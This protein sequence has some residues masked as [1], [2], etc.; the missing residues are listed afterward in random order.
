MVSSIRERDYPF[1]TDPESEIG[2]G[3]HCL[4]GNDL[5]GYR[6]VY[7]IRANLSAPA[8]TIPCFLSP[9]ELLTD[10]SK[11]TESARIYDS[12]FFCT[13][14]A[15]VFMLMSVSLLF[16]YA[17]FI[18]SIGG[19]EWHL[20][21][22]VGLG[23]VGAILFR[24]YQGTAIDR[25]GPMVVWLLSLAGLITGNL[26]HIGITDVNH[27]T[28]YATRFLL[29]LCIAGV[30]GSWLSF[31]SLR[32]PAQRV[33]E[34]IGVVGSSGFV[35]MAIGPVL[36]DMIFG[37][38]ASLESS[39]DMMFY[40]SAALAF[41]SLI[42]AA[43][44]G[45]LD[46]R[47]RT[48]RDEAVHRRPKS[49][50]APG[51]W[52]LL[53]NYHP[54]FVLVVAG[55]MGLSIS[56]PGNF[57][58]PFAAEQGIAEIKLFFLVYNIVAFVSRVLFR[59]APEIMGLRNAILLGLFLMSLSMVLYTQVH[60]TTSLVFPAIAG[61]LA[62]SFLFP[63]V[64]TAATAFFPKENRGLATSLVLAMYD[65]GVLVGS[66]LVGISVTTARGMGWPEY[67]L[68]FC[69]VSVVLVVIGILAWRMYDR[70]DGQEMRRGKTGR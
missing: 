63:S 44:A 4:I 48:S 34:V 17:D 13:Y 68:T 26:L 40:V 39:V 55:V 52:H 46:V 31:V 61:G 57:L 28:V 5:V 20:G 53:R 51:I 66:P 14:V 62:H 1:I 11:N 29:N 9:E 12:V 27:W 23:T 47:M 15:N 3:E 30:F 8:D 2:Q 43:A 33:A 21:W 38:S 60:S 58:R 42:A 25:F 59:R 10:T 54:G 45:I 41:G 49:S 37:R 64:V 16:R 32:V 36:G 18:K 7:I 24:V 69:V 6:R 56:L 19:N 35:G 22:I 67:P 70:G 50:P 65:F